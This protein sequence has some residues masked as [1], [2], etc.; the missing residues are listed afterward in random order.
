M[1]L[2]QIYAFLAVAEMGSFSKAGESMYLSQPTISRYIH[3]LE[4][5]LGIDLLKRGQKSCELT[6]AGARIYLHATQMV[7]EWEQICEEA[8]IAAAGKQELLRIGYTYNEILPM[9]TL[10]LS[11]NEMIR[12]NISLSLRFGE[13]ESV[14]QLVREGE[15]DC[16]VL[17]LP[18]I[19]HRERLQ[20]QVIRE[21][22][23]SIQVHRK[24][25]LA[26]FDKLQVADLGGKTDVRVRSEAPFYR[27]AD[28]AFRM[29]GVKPLEHVYVQYSDECLPVLVAKGGLCLTP[30]IYSPAQD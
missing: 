20:I 15:L 26:R 19:V 3:E 18:S 29:K 10:A 1:K 7:R 14:A 4:G 30:S 12:N 28:E 25:P 8:K 5:E 2:E 21:C 23:M 13:G 24:S 11:R 16:A 27:A 6:T 22:G 17:H 9:I